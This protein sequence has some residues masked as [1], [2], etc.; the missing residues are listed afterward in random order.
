M[1]GGSLAA[2]EAAKTVL[3]PM[4]KRFFHCGDIGMGSVRNCNT[5]FFNILCRQTDRH[6]HTQTD[7]HIQ[8]HMLDCKALL[9]TFHI[10]LQQY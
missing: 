5:I 7:R 8:T 6:T 4:G 10:Q 2:V 1:M 3:E 9:L